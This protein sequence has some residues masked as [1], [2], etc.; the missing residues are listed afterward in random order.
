MFDFEE[1]DKV[2]ED[3]D[4]DSM[5]FDDD[6]LGFDN[7]DEDFDDLS[8]DDDLDGSFDDEPTFEDAKDDGELTLAAEASIFMDDLRETFATDDEFIQY[9]QENAVEWEL[10]GL[11]PSASRALEA[12]KTI[13]VD[14][15]KKKNRQRLIRRECI[16]IACKKNDPNY[17][18]YKK[19]RTLMR[20]Y[21]QKIFDKYE[22]KARSNVMKARNNSLAK[23]SNI[24]T[25]SGKNLEQRVKTSKQVSEKGKNPTHAPNKSK[26]N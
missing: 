23:A 3:I 11:I 9:V 24:K 1:L 4:D 22:S 8:D 18:K 16:R 2:F 7:S 15:W 19:Y 13:K 10:Y 20:Q 21:R 25:S 5:D 17:A 6:E 14:D 12:I 26:A